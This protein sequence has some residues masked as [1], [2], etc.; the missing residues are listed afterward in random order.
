MRIQLPSGAASST[1]GATPA[2]AAARWQATSRSASAPGLGP[3]Q[4][5]CRNTK[6]PTHVSMRR[7][8]FTLRLPCSSCTLR[9]ASPPVHPGMRR[10]SDAGI[11]ERSDADM[12]S[13]IQ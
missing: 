9:G 3:S 12:S 1:A 10:K 4:T 2:A 7:L 8:R 6:R 11:T 13:T 5:R